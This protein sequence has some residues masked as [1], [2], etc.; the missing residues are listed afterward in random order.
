MWISPAFH[1]K[2]IK[3]FDRGVTEGV[4]VSE[5][6]AEDLLNDP[7]SFMEK[8]M[9]Q[10]KRLK[11]ERDAAQAKL[12]VAEPKAL[13]FDT[14][15]ADK[16]MSVSAFCRTLLRTSSNSVNQGMAINP[17]TH[18]YRASCALLWPLAVVCEGG[19]LTIA[20]EIKDFRCPGIKAQSHYPGSRGN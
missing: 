12:E 11:A 6:A 2:V 19:T 16:S 20:T 3:F 8:V 10:A 18:P 5:H 9:A 17:L 7:L 15:M 13:V 1:L 14:S 4:A